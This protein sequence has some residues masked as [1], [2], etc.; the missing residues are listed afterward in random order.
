MPFRESSEF[1]DAE[2]DEEKANNDFS[3]SLECPF[4]PAGAVSLVS[5]RA[6]GASRDGR[7]APL[8]GAR[9]GA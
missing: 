8:A 9:G 3:I 1:F 5:R 7:E 2:A 6:Q 4:K